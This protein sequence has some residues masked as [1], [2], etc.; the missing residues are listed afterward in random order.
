MVRN[1]VGTLIEIGRGRWQP[2]RIDHILASRDRR[3]A[4]PT[5]LPDGLTLV[6]VHYGQEYSTYQRREATAG[7]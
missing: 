5:A 6:C 3:E 4:G 7:G 2:D 1:I